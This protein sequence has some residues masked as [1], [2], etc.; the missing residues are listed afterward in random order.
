MKPT[1]VQIKALTILKDT[2]PVKGM[3]PRDFSEK[4]WKDSHPDLF[5][6]VKNTGNGATSGKAAWLCAGSYL[7]KLV[8]KGLV[9]RNVSNH[10]EYRI[11]SKGKDVILF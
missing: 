5:T 7:N 10:T 4:M 6:K 1:K 11:T 8:A 3:S 9:Q 2:T